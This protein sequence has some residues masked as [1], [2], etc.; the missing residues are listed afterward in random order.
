MEIVDLAV[1][2]IIDLDFKGNWLNNVFNSMNAG[3]LIT[4]PLQEDNPIIYSNEKFS[5][6]T[7]YKQEEILG[8]NCRFLQGK[9]T[10]RSSVAKIRESLNK[11]EECQ[12]TLLNYRKDGSPFWN[13]LYLAPIFDSEGNLVNFVGIQ[14]EVE[15]PDNNDG[16]TS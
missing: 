3:L 16:K 6:M 14:H 9:D 4:D 1:K 2:K 12:Y 7:G 11:K 5:E 15:G 10:D 8:L 13:R